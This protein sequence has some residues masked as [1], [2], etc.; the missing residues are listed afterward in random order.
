MKKGEICVIL[1]PNTI[2]RIHEIRSNC[3]FPVS[4]SAFPVRFV[5]EGEYA[6]AAPTAGCRLVDELP[7][8][9]FAGSAPAD[10]RPAEAGRGGQGALCTADD[11]ARYKNYLPLQSD[12]LIGIAAQYYKKKKDPVRLAKSR[13]YTGCVYAE[14][15][16]LTTAADYYLQAARMMP[17]GADD[18]FTAMVCSQLGD[19]YKD[20]DLHAD[21]KSMHRKAYQLSLKEDSVRACHCLKNIGDFFLLESQQDSAFY[22][23]Q[24][25]LQVASQLKQPYLLSL[26]YKKMAMFYYEQGKHTEADIYISKALQQLA[27]KENYASACYIKGNILHELQQND[28]AVYY[29]N[30][31]RESANI[32][33]K[34]SCYNK[35]YQSCK[36]RIQHCE[37]ITMYIDSFLAL[38]DSIQSLKDRAELSNLM[39]KHQIELHKHKMTIRN[40]R[41]IAM[42][43]VSALILGIL[44]FAHDR[45][46][47]KKLLKLQQRLMEIHA[48]TILLH[49]EGNAPQEEQ[50]G[51]LTQLSKERWELC[52]SLFAKTEGYEMLRKIK[53]EANPI[54]RKNRIEEYRI[55]IIRDIRKSFADVMGD[56]KEN[57]PALTSDDLLY[58]VF[59]LLRCPNNII[60]KIK[61]TTPDALRT[62]KSRIKNKVGEELSLLIFEH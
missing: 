27:G 15:Q 25:A 43:L 28:S 3:F 24:Q 32:Y 49:E 55:K 8:G 35:L 19:C 1:P 44:F 26:L 54:E 18:R 21:A 60:E 20:Q 5:P 61:G 36:S 42:I 16:D 9:Q 48:E 38:H 4:F 17:E 11:A 46:Q 59:S 13:F 2:D 45:V 51:K 52:T 40:Q 7:P 29:W 37:E 6:D 56:L 31:G 30:K 14:R 47:R 23:Y 39:D 33:V 58:C 62:R 12:S 10:L 50:K 41:L 22:Y 57:Y 53:E 34:A